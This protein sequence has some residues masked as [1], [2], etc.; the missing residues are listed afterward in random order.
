M[1]LFYVLFSV[2]PFYRLPTAAGGLSLGEG[3]ASCG[4]SEYL[5]RV[6]GM[7]P[8]PLWEC[9]PSLVP[10]TASGLGD[11][12][13][14]PCQAISSGSTVRRYNL[15]EMRAAD[16]CS[17]LHSTAPNFIQHTFRHCLKLTQI[18]HNHCHL[19]RSIA[20]GRIFFLLV[21]L[22][23]WEPRECVVSPTPYTPSLYSHT[24]LSL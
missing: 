24:P 18:R 12:S 21:F 16:E 9:L 6:V 17:Q 2:N 7:P 23:F 15:C 14:Q 8:I 10:D 3:N 11:V 4:S 13:R 20:L 19:T 22:E 1:F 5:L